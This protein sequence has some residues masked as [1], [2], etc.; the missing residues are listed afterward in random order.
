[1][2]LSFRSTVAIISWSPDEGAVI[3]TFAQALSPESIAGNSTTSKSPPKS[4]FTSL[5]PAFSEPVLD[6]STEISISS[7]ELTDSGEVRI[8]VT[9][10]SGNPATVMVLKNICSLVY[11]KTIP[12]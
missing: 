12:I 6:T 9:S 2:T 3:V 11:L 1:M 10:K 5:P 8:S 4:I 7:P